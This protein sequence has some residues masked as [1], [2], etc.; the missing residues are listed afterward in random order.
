MRISSHGEPE[1]PTDD[2][3][4]DLVSGEKHYRNSVEPEDLV[5]QP[6]VENLQP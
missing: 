3:Y 2:L 4:D 1:Y 5:T 6:N